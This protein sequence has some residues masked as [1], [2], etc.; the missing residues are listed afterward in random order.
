MSTYESIMEGLNEAVRYQQGKLAARKVKLTIKPV[1][2]FNTED[3][4]L[5]QEPAWFFAKLRL[6]YKSFKKR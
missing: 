6:A 5:V 2:T 1:D 3:I 4:G